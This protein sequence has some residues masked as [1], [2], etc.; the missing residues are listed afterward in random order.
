MRLRVARRAVIDIAFSIP[1][2]GLSEGSATLLKD[3]TIA[4]VIAAAGLGLARI[5]RQPSVLGYLLAGAIIG[6]VHAAHTPHQ[7]SG[8]HRASG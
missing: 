1:T 2:A 8:Y 5:A 4:M 7:R 6:A 3:F